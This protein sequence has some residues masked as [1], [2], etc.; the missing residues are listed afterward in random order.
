MFHLCDHGASRTTSQH[1][2]DPAKSQ[3]T[4]LAVLVSFTRNSVGLAPCC[5]PSRN[6]R[7]EE[8]RRCANSDVGV[9][10]HTIFLFAALLFFGEF[11]TRR[12]SSR[13]LL[14]APGAADKVA[15]ISI[16]YLSYLVWKKICESTYCSVHFIRDTCSTVIHFRRK[17]KSRQRVLIVVTKKSSACCL[18]H[19][20]CNGDKNIPEGVCKM[21]LKKKKV[22]EYKI[23]ESF[24]LWWRFTWLQWSH[25]IFP[26]WW[27][28]R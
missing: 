4:R 22:P 12:L 10:S 21:H 28:C 19:R 15:M 27:R 14:Q 18:Q 20:L 6:V 7:G 13:D 23:I 26:V 25:Q 8:K 11:S 2:A 1:G 9:T 17:K 3:Q 24:P 16:F 5:K